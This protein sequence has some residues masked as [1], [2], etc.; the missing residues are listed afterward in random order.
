MICAIISENLGFKLQKVTLEMLGSWKNDYYIP[1]RIC[2]K[3]YTFNEKKTHIL[4]FKSK[5][6]FQ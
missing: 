4:V 5:L 1:S 3:S 6:G 2:F